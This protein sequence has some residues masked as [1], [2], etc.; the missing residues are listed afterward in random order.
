[1]NRACY[2]GRVSS[3]VTVRLAIPADAEAFLSL[4]DGLAD[5]ERL[6]RP[7][8]DARRR[9]ASDP[10]TEPPR[11]T[12]LLAELDGEVVGYAASFW[13]YST[14]LALPTLYLEDIFVLPEARGHGAGAALFRACAAEAVRQGCGRM[15]WS[16]LAWNQPSID[17]YERRGAT[18]LSDWLPFRLA[19]EALLEAG[20]AD[21]IGA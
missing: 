12:L 14:F 4:V 2:S 21:P 10:F 7:D 13:T 17:F 19:G 18:H 8:P 16:V 11:F 5:Y 15:E 20:L 6:P 9:L 3:S 1:L